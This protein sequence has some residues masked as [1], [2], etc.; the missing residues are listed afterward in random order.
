MNRTI[1]AISITPD[2]LKI[3][4]LNFQNGRNY[5]RH[6]QRLIHSEDS[7]SGL[8]DELRRFVNEQN[9]K[10]LKTVL[11]FSSKD[12]AYREFSFPFDSKKK[13]D[14]AIRFEIFSEFSP[15]EYIFDHI[16]NVT[17]KQGERSFL[18]A[19]AKKETIRQKIVTLE[20]AGF[21]IIGI[22]SDLSTLGNYYSSEDE[23][24]VLEIGKRWTLLGLFSH[25]LPVLVRGIPFV[26]GET[27]HSF[28]KADDKSI[29]P[30]VG[31]IKRTIHSFRAKTGFDLKR[32][33]VTGDIHAHSQLLETLRTDLNVDITDGP[34]N[35][36]H[37]NGENGELNVYAS[38]IGVGEWKRKGSFFD[39]LKN[40]FVKED[41]RAI[42]RSYIRW[43][44]MILFSTMFAVLMSFWLQTSILEARKD[45][46]REEIRNTFIAAFPQA[47]RIVDE[48]KQA[49]N[50]LSNNKTSLGPSGHATDKSILEVIAKISG[51]IPEHISFQIVSMFWERGKLEING[52][53]DTFGSANTVQELLSGVEPFSDVRISDARIRGEDE[54]VEFKV[55]IRLS[56]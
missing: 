43:G 7:D 4:E 21:K 52:R 33:Y 29:G 45:F 6:L 42:K 56:K 25:G 2:Y 36:F 17:K 47:K 19:I 12:L 51:A 48:V 34:G 16:E 14:N 32:T 24:L 5:V 11:V 8:V 10:T 55:T 38:L 44:T 37:T 50:F 18:A 41:P 23:A 53:T 40:E 28:E 31:E 9:P 27:N 20:K 15:D 49:R 46:L 39:L 22:T 3:A 13:V 35:G 1:I 26:L 30:L 54:D